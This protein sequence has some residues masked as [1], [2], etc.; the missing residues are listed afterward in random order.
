MCPI[1][2]TCILRTLIGLFE[3][4][5]KPAWS[6]SSASKSKEYYENF[7]EFSAGEKKNSF[8]TEE[9][10]VKSSFLVKKVDGGNGL[11]CFKKFIVTSIVNFIIGVT[12]DF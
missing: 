5:N 9:W 4:D 10:V 1:C 2:V 8:K 12:R 3:I 6:T 11:F 7:Q